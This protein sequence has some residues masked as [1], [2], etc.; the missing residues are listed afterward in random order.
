MYFEIFFFFFFTV[1][2]STPPS[3]DDGVLLYPSHPTPALY[4]GQAMLRFA[5]FSYTGV[6][7]MLGLP[8][9]QCP[10]GIGLWGVPLGVQVGGAAGGVAGRGG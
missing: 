3:G 8:S 9:T 4:H 10:L 1:L 7:N 5:N 2:S 6:I